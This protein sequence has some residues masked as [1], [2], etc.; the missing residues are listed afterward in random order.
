[1]K[2]IEINEDVINVLFVIGYIIFATCRYYHLPVY[3]LYLLIGFFLLNLVFSIRL[4]I[5]N[6]KTK[7]NMGDYLRVFTNFAMIG[8]I[9]YSV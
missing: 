2:K 6:R 9:V 3:V 1:M 7:N 5:R 8:L 4:F